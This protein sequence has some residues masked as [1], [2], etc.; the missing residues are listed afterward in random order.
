[1]QGGQNRRR[2]AEKQESQMEAPDSSRMVLRLASCDCPSLE[3]DTVP[4]NLPA[5]EVA[6]ANTDVPSRGVLT[7]G[8]RL[9]VWR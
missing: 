4:V 9:S 2:E 8:S 3:G 7:V 1:M 6:R 5:A